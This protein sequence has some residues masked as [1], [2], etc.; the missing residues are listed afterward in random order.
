MIDSE[1]D[2]GRSCPYSPLQMIQRIYCQV[3]D[4]SCDTK[5]TGTDSYRRIGISDDWSGAGFIQARVGLIKRISQ[6]GVCQG[7]EALMKMIPS[8]SMQIRAQ[9]GLSRPVGAD[10]DIDDR[11]YTKEENRSRGKMAWDTMLVT[12]Y[13]EEVLY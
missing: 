4:V 12:E 5:L 6:E 3:N 2:P 9:K 11:Y 10:V 13:V 1:R 8:N 7:D